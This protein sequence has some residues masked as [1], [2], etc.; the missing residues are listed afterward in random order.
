M[1]TFANAS[2][3]PNYFYADNTLASVTSG[4]CA[5]KEEISALVSLYKT[6]LRAFSSKTKKFAASVIINTLARRNAETFTIFYNTI[7]TCG[8]LGKKICQ[9]AVVSM[10]HVCQESGKHEIYGKTFFKKVVKTENGI[11]VVSF[12]FDTV[13]SNVWSSALKFAKNHRHEILTYRLEKEAKKE[14]SWLDR[15]CALASTY[16]E[17]SDKSAQ[18]KESSAQ[19]T[20]LERINRQLDQLPKEQKQQVK[21]MLFQLAI[22]LKD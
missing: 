17:A 10:F 22:L 14:Q 19:A 9:D 2:I 16:K 4:N 3:N 13:K 6:D 1:T 20:G 12:K 7:S 8:E 11:K 15:I 18:G 5:N 21:D